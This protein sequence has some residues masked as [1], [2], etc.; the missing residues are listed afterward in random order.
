M[1]FTLGRKP[2]TRIRAHIPRMGVATADVEIQ[3]VNV[4]AGRQ[5]LV[6]GDLALE[7]VIEP[8]GG[9]VAGVAT[10]E[11]TA[12]AGGWKTTIPARGYDSS[13]GILRS[14]ILRDAAQAC[15][16]TVVIGLAEQRLGLPPTGGYLRLAGR[17]WDTLEALGVPWYV[18][19]AGVTQISERPAGTAPADGT[20]VYWERD[21]GRRIVVPASE[22]VAAWLPGRTFEGEIIEALDIEAAAGE[23][24]KLILTLGTRGDLRALLTEQRSAPEQRARYY[25]R[26]RY[27]VVKRNGN[28]YDLEP[29]DKTIGLQDITNRDLWMGAPGH[30][31]LLPAGYLVL[32]SFLDGLPSE[33][34]VDG[35]VRVNSTQVDDSGSLPARVV[36]DAA[37]AVWLGGATRAVARHEDTVSVGTLALTGP[38]VAGTSNVWTLLYTPPGAGVP[39]TYVLTTTIAGTIVSFVQAGGGMLTGVI[40]Q[41]TQNKVFA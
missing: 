11:W 22:K 19:A 2:I 1:S 13:Q 10:Y 39:T 31:A 27:K 17:A 12:G 38:V 7:G 14:T 34:V 3:G 37:N 36:I 30:D 23:P 18:D 35:Y 29:L 5:Q 40:D 32:V 20:T 26:Y 21:L 25:G 41:P 8:G 15:G 16:E 6:I 24:I 4:L 28:F 33:P 9:A